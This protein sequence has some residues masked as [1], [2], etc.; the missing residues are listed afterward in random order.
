VGIFLGI[1]ASN[2]DFGENTTFAADPV[3][4]T[5]DLE[6][7]FY[8]GITGTL[9]IGN[10]VGWKIGGLYY[11][12]PGSDTDGIS[13]ANPR[14]DYDYVE[15]YGALSYDFGKFNVAAGLNYSPDYFFESDDAVYYYGDVGIPLPMDFG[16]FG[17]V[18]HQEIDNNL[19]FGTP[20]YTDWNVGVSKAWKIFTLKLSY[21]DTD[22]SETDCFG[23]TDFCDGTALFS[24]TAAY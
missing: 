9:P 18:G 20:D 15:A 23:G 3:Q 17:H 6:M 8:G 2:L 5:A 22:L 7:D 16:L 19:Q 21:V 10:G 1:W 12:Y 13:G 4:D 24:I 14:A 11:A